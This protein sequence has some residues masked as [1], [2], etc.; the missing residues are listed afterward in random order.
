MNPLNLVVD[1]LRILGERGRVYN[2]P[3]LTSSDQIEESFSR[4][5]QIAALKLNKPVSAYDVATILESVKDARLAVSPAHYD[6]HVDKINYSA[7]RGAFS[8]ATPPAQNTVAP[9][10][11]EEPPEDKPTDTHFFAEIEKEGPAPSPEPAVATAPEPAPVATPETLADLVVSANPAVPPETL[12][13]AA[14]SV[15][16]VKFIAP[17]VRAPSDAVEAIQAKRD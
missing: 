15:T 12:A 9:A 13:D 2:N 1:A 7:F 4:A 6:S 16:P 11:A 8:G 10:P 17:G 5:A 3:A 14:K